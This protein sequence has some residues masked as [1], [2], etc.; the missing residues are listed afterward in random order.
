MSDNTQDNKRLAKNTL[1]LYIR[2]FIFLLVGLY[3]SR[4]VLNALGVVDYGINNVV[5][6]IAAIFASLNGAMAS[7][8]SR[9]ITFYLGKGDQERLKEI[10]STV[11]IVHIGIGIIVVLLC[12]T[13]GIWF[14][15]NK[16]Q[17]PAERMD[18]AFWLLQFS[19]IGCFLGIINTPFEG[20]I[21]AHEKMDIYAYISI[22][23]VV[24]KLVIVFIIQV[25]PFDKLF[26]YGLLYLLVGFIDFLI[27]RTYSVR[28]FSEAHIKRFFDKPLF[29][30]LANYFGWSI[31][32]NVA[33]AFNGQ[34]I[35]MVLNMFF[36]P[37]VNAARGVAYSVQNIINQFVG[38]FQIALNPQI[39]KT[40][41]N[42]EM[43]RMYTLMYASSKYGFLLLFFLSL[44]V[45]I[46]A[47]EILTLWLGIVPEHTIAFLRIILMTCM[48]NAMAN[49]SIVAA[50]ATGKIRKYT[51]VN[52][53]F[54]LTPLPLSYIT[55]KFVHIPELVFV[56]L[57]IVEIATLGS[58]LYMMRTMIGLSIKEYS[59][60][61]FFPA[62]LVVI[63]SVWLPIG[64]HLMTVE[65]L[66][67][68]I[69]VCFVSAFITALSIYFLGLNK[70]ERSMAN[71][72]IRKKL[73]RK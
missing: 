28:S 56:I 24:A 44:P 58:R 48:I 72:I 53:C 70:K 5:G 34:G 35:N 46:C 8:S 71:E 73:L 9:Y 38:N 14:F 25:T 64:V 36:G 15:Y 59:K 61:V 45:M 3:T 17:I 6:G 32:G 12:E 18:V 57:L 65:N 31:F 63:T 52:S 55:L 60:H 13:I 40:Y 11:A 39:V 26:V 19:F 27:Y 51:L 33:L 69:L 47:K 20:L 66:I 50:G 67:N 16:M 1:F 30:E 7:T 23:D 62:F 10:F 2:M 4:V 21:V 41:A 43:Q 37:A 29:K 42:K 49:S 68:T 54:V 22:F